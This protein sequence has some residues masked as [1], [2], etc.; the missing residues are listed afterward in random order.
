[1]EALDEVGGFD[2]RD[3][4]IAEMRELCAREIPLLG[5]PEP[6]ARVQSLA[7]DGPAGPVPLR[8]FHP[9]AEAGAATVAATDRVLLWLHGG[10]WV[11]GDLELADTECR[12]L[13]RANGAVVV[14]VDYRL[15]PEHPYPAGLEDA[16][17]ALG[18]VDR[19]FRDGTDSS[20]RLIVGGDSSGGNLAAALCLLARDRGGPTIDH[21]LLLYPITDWAFETD[22]YLRYGEGYVLTAAGMKAYWEL[23]AGD[24]GRPGDPLLSVL[25]ADRVDGLPTATIVVAGCDVLRDEVEAY[26]TKLQAAGVAVAVLRYPGQIHGFWSYAGVCDLVHSVDAEI[27]AAIERALRVTG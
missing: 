26:A 2:R 24:S 8:V 18:W 10:G 11:L 13:C 21:Q 1:M 5:E 9:P 23:Y 4:S 3:V 16:Y 15:A 7:I 14:A 17:A 12:R 22:S 19:E 25:R 20:P 6:V 27:G